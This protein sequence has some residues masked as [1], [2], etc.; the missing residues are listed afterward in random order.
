MVFRVL[1]RV[2][3][4]VR[5]T[6]FAVGIALVVLSASLLLPNLGAITQVFGTSGISWQ[7][8]ASFLFSLYGSLFT[9]FSLLSGLN[10]LLVAVFFGINITLLVYYI[11]RQQTVSR[12]TGVH[13]SSLG[14]LVSGIFGIGC[15]ACGSVIVT[16][17][18]GMFGASGLIAL[19]PFHGAEF[20]LLGV[21][22]LVS[23]I[24]YLIKKI[25]DPLVCR[26]HSSRTA[27]VDGA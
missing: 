3:R 1:K 12:N 22:L 26:L 19:L 18:L 15:A 8:K 20:G 21:V 14:G 6:V 27:T 24:W 7:M 17:L 23:S 11:R 5:Y 4:Q 2:F 9:N 13:M 25:N 10:L 16:S